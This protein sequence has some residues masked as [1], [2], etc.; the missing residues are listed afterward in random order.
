MKLS[1]KDFMIYAANGT[2]MR[3]T[4]GVP[5]GFFNLQA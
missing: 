1:W 4:A 5:G 3:L 2:I